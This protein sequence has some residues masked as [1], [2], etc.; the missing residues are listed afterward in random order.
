MD[1]QM[2]AAQLCEKHAPMGQIIHENRT[3]IGGESTIARL[4]KFGPPK[5]S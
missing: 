4:G 5:L 3:R 2:N 1:S